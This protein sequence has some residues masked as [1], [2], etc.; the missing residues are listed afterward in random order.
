MWKAKGILTNLAQNSRHLQ[1]I[2][3]A[4]KHRNDTKILLMI[5]YQ[6]NFVQNDFANAKWIKMGFF[7]LAVLDFLKSNIYRIKKRQQSWHE[8]QL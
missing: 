8:N 7:P 3:E 1:N 2:L 4:G 5:S 6:E